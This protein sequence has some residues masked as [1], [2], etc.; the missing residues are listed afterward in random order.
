MC[1]P[2]DAVVGADQCY[3][4]FWSMHTHTH[5]HTRSLSFCLSVTLLSFPFFPF[6]IETLSPIILIINWNTEFNVLACSHLKVTSIQNVI[7]NRN[8]TLYSKFVILLL[9]DANALVYCKGYTRVCTTLAHG[10]SD[11]RD[12]LLCKSLKLQK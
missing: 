5:T 8:L 12:I 2:T 6:H 11:K 3:H 10:Y 7:Y 1:F 4:W 9:Q